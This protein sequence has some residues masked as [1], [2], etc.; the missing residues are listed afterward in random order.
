MTSLVECPKC[1]WV[2]EIDPENPA[3][4]TTCERC[5]EPLPPP[6]AR[7]SS[8]PPEEPV[9]AASG[10]ENDPLDALFA[11]APTAEPASVPAPA[12]A[13]APDPVP[14]APVAPPSL[15][16]APRP[17]AAEGTFGRPGADG[18]P[19]YELLEKVGHD[20]AGTV[21]HARDRESGRDVA[22][23]FLPAQSG[24]PQTAALERYLKKALSLEHS[25]ILRVRD[26]GRRGDQIY[27]ASDYLPGGSLTGS[28]DTRRLC[29]V[30]RDAALGVHHAHQ[31]GVFHGDLHPGQVLVR[32]EQGQEERGVVK[33]FRLA[34]ALESLTPVAAGPA[35]AVPFVRNPAYLAPELAEQRTRALSAATDVY[36]LGATLYALL[37]G[38]PPFEGRTVGQMLGRIMMEEPIAIEKVCPDVPEPLAAVI[39][40]SMAKDVS[41]RFP[42]AKHFADALDKILQL[43]PTGETPAAAPPPTQPEKP[44]EEAPKPELVSAPEPQPPPAP[45]PVAPRPAVPAPAAPPEKRPAR[46]SV[47]WPAAAAF[48]LI[49]GGGAF[50]LF[51]PAAPKETARAVPASEPAPVVPV[52]PGVL[53][54]DAAPLPLELRVDGRPVDPA[55]KT[56]S[57]PPGSHRVEGVFENQVRLERTVD[58]TSGQIRTVTLR[59]HRQIA[60]SWEQLERW[61][62]AEAA[63]LEAQKRPANEGERRELDQE[64]ARIRARRLEGESVLRVESDPPGAEVVLDGRP[65]GT[66]PISLR[67][68]KSGD[69]VVELRRDG[70]VSESRRVSIQAGNGDVLRAELK[71]RA[72]VVRV[73]GAR[74]GDVVKML[75]RDG[76]PARSVTAGPEGGAE[77]ASMPLGDYDVVVERR[78]HEPARGRAVVEEGR[79]VVVSA[80][81]FKEKPGTLAVQSDPEGAEVSVE[82]RVVGRTPLVMQA[83]PAGAK[84]VR[85][86]HAETLDWDGEV[87]VVGDERAEVKATLVRAGRLVVDAHPEGSRVSG[88]LD[89]TNR[90]QGKLKAGEHKVRVEHPE[91]GAAE[92]TVAVRAGEEV[93]ERVDLWEERAKAAEKSGSME[94]ALRAY[95]KARK[96][97]REKA[98]A[99]LFEACLTE[100][101]AQLKDRQWKRARELADLA[102]KV[103]P[104]DARVRALVA[105]AGFQEGLAG[106]E[107]ALRLRDWARARREAEKAAALRRGDPRAAEIVLTARLEGALA[108]GR[109]AEGSGRWSA[110][111]SAYEEV[112]TIRPGNTDA[113]E[114]LRRLA[115][116]DWRE[117][118]LLPGFTL[119]VAFSPS[120]KLLALGGVDKSIRLWDVESSRVLRTLSG[121]AGA[122]TSLSFHADGETL[123]SA[124]QDGTVKVWNASS[125]RLA[126]TLSG[127]SGPV[128]SVAFAA[129]G[130]SLASGGEDRTIRV[131][132][133]VE[134]KEISSWSAHGGPVLTVAHAPNGGKHLASGGG[135]GAVK[136]WEAAGVKPLRT[137]VGHTAAV[138]HLAFSPDGKKIASGSGD[139]SVRLWDVQEGKELRTFAGHSKGVYQVAFRPDG[140]LIAS[141]GGD[142]MVRL[143]HAEAGGEVRAL[144]GHTS[145]VWSVA[146]TPSGDALLSGGTDGTR[147]WSR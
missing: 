123:A 105:D 52:E 145:D 126:A 117:M 2:H 8:A 40:R 57:L 89:G 7:P 32:Q 131:W 140:R 82:G 49:L 65:A 48:V 39:R 66:T 100:A 87:R 13:P 97:T 141:S 59:A 114:G 119:S 120:G 130:K 75:T 88:A 35:A 6:V 70:Y 99:R 51:K 25:G 63:L 142:R 86:T 64:L 134:G 37:A 16:V 61:P 125:G 127:H 28:K 54:L 139:K 1:R 15:T 34:H 110:A 102:M 83:V 143:W 68:L 79:V 96:E 93:T 113:E 103:R 133:P 104:G 30:L 22:V 50:F 23:R 124:S 74:A 9:A 132:D 76:R 146:F 38:R 36:G 10:G 115:V 95:D 144:T 71:P 47:L 12:P 5:S 137:F 77:F 29:A 92:R 91:A 101:A 138:Y 24:E 42:D 73:P 69:H 19:R 121:H 136:L 72:G 107:E 94:D 111:K 85:L 81:E 78:G 4:R 21:F 128:W 122:V 27:V 118:P 56:L 108:Q 98:V 90:V 80:L 84:K 14:S 112:R 43:G 33:D 46:R 3:R 116:L 18:Q 55:H 129:D 135:D 41:L 106:A 26:T 44:K 31:Q 20:L 58:V 60:R 67:G 147:R 17:A 109:E 62:E 45:A 53:E 11:P